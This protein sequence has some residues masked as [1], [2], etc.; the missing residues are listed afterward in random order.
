MQFKNQVVYKV[1]IGD[2][3]SNDSAEKASEQLDNIEINSSVEE[4]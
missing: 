3:A 2:F 1:L 4:F